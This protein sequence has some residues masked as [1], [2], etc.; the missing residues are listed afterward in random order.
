MLA[1]I[2]PVAPSS[3]T[4]RIAGAAENSERP[5]GT[6]TIAFT[7][8][9]ARAPGVE[10][11]AQHADDRR[12]QGRRQETVEP[13]HHAAMAGDDVTGVLGAEPALDRRLQQIAGL[14]D[15]RQQQSQ[16][17][18]SERI[19]QSRRQRHRRS[20]Q[21]RA[22]GAADRAGPGL[23]RA[24]LPPQFRP[25][26]GAAGE[27]AENVGRPHDREQEDES[28]ETEPAV[29]PQRRRRQQDHARVEDSGGRPAPPLTIRQ[30][31]D[32]QRAEND[33]RAREYDAGQVSRER[34]AGE[35]RAGNDDA[36]RV[37]ALGDH[38]IHS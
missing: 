34:R 28:D 22:D 12:H 23:F 17:R 18:D 1:P 8:P 24:D 35:D 38:S 9:V 30:R 27:I 31:C 20:R 36:G 33:Q 19:C 21:D 7:T 5:S 16:D 3:V 26:D 25:A 29:L 2:E 32:D 6:P 13:V 37:P 10:A 15:R 4:D 11:A 14:R